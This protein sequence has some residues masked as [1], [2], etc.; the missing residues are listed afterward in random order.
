MSAAGRKVLI[1][2][3]CGFVGSHLCEELLERGWSVAGLVLQAKEGC[4]LKA[5]DGREFGE[6]ISNVEHLYDRVRLI[7]GDL[8]DPP[9]LRRA[10]GEAGADYIVHLAAA[11]APAQSF[12]RPEFFF[13]IN[14]LGTLNLLEAVRAQGGAE[15]VLLFTSAEVYGLLDAAALP[16]TESAPLAPRNPYAASKTACHYLGRQYALNFGLPIVEVRPFNMIG[17]R[18]A[19]DFVLPDF[20]S[21]VAEIIRGAREPVISVGRL[22]DRRDFTDVRDA[23][24]AAAELLDKGTPGET[25]HICSGVPTPVRRILDLLLEAA[26]MKI[27]VVQDPARLRPAA[28]PVLYGSRDK[29]TALTGWE[30]TIPLE[31]T[32]QDVLGYWNK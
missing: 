18:Q 28:M 25:Y 21:Q 24:R 6:G 27:K 3:I 4:G 14:A 12:A 8:L 19:L 5:P 22:S 13:E 17:P 23:V 30:P 16:V 10:L 31:K 32:V 9:G 11:S 1:T 26:G 29:L 20:A 2:G 15:K 7:P